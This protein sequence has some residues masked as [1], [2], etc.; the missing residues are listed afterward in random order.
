MGEKCRV[1]GAGRGS[2]SQLL[3]WTFLI[4]WTYSSVSI[5]RRPDPVIYPKELISVYLL[6]SYIDFTCCL[7]VLNKNTYVDLMFLKFYIRWIVLEIC[8]RN[9]TVIYK[10]LKEKNKNI[11]FNYSCNPIT[12]YLHL[13]LNINIFIQ[14]SNLSNKLGDLRT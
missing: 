9:I 14:L 3:F 8:T 2:K 4:Y 1:R 5:N 7:L 12:V 11:F 10:T 6:F 13:V